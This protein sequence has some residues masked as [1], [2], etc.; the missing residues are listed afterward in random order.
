VSTYLQLGKFGDQVSILPILQ[1]EFRNTGKKPTLI[2]AK[3]YS[4][5]VEGLDFLEVAI[6][7][8]AY[9]DISDA[10][11]WAKSKFSNVVVPQ[12]FGSDYSIQRQCPGFQLDQWNRCGHLDKWGRIGLE[13]LRYKKSHIER[14]CVEMHI[15]ATNRT[16]KSPFILVG[17]HSQSSPFSQVE[18]LCSDLQ[19][20]FPSHQV[21]R[22]S[23]VRFTRPTD[24]LVIYDAADLLVTID[25]LHLHLSIATKTPVIALATD[26]PGRWRGSSDHPR[27]A[28]YCRYGDYTL[29]KQQLLKAAK[30]AVN[31][32]RIVRAMPVQISHKHGYNLS[33]LRVGNN[34]WMTY[35]HHPNPASWRTEMT[36]EISNG[37]YVTPVPIVPPKKYDLHSQEDGRLFMFRGKPHISVTISRSFLNGVKSPCITGYGELSSDGKITNWVEPQIG[38]N[39]WNGQEKNWVFFEYE[40]KLHVIY[41]HSP[42]LVV[43]ALDDSGRVTNEYK[44]PS[45]QSPL[46][47][48]RGGTQPIPYKDGYLRFCHV[49]S[50]NKKSDVWWL[51]HIVAVLMESKPPFRILKISDPIISGDET[52][53]PGHKFWKPRCRLPYGAV[54]DECNRK[55]LV[56]LG[57]NDSACELLEL[58]EEQIGI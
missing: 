17:D 27:F 12:V 47:P 49:N 30:A 51:Y 57:A 21:V 44:T 19:S 23:S 56:S 8:G 53:Y 45:P 22:L 42:E 28:F 50:V 54:K 5:L 41:Q 14:E 31:K 37:V 16:P 18:E 13:L 52:F 15:E 55:F 6:Y 36:L 26:S 46:G 24:L 58:T 34:S 7:P 10:I 25:T 48:V 35:R 39:A 2:V 11:K 40:N 9:H 4:S 20:A 1:W 32:S 43:Y 33:I 38:K 29:R 3:E